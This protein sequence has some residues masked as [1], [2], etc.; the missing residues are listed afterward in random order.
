ML[1]EVILIGANEDLENIPKQFISVD[2]LL[3][4]FADLEKTT[5]EKSAQ[6]LL[7]HIHILNKT[8]KLVLK[9]KYTLIEYE[10][11]NNDFYNCPIEAIR[12]I[13]EGEEVFVTDSIGFA[14]LTILMS[15][16][17]IGLDI[18]DNIIKNSHAYISP[19]CYENDDNFY[20]NQCAY[21]ISIINNNPQ[22]KLPIK[23]E[24]NINYGYL[25][26][27]N[28]QAYMHKIALLMRLTH[29]LITLNRF[30]EEATKQKRIAFCLEEYGQY[31]GVANT[32]TNVSHFAN[33]INTRDSSKAIVADVMSKMLSQE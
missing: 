8:K 6:W 12:L 25:L 29:D 4:L 7:N 19:N 9:N 28:N 3:N 16:K 24:Q 26:N 23:Q 20:K 33:L 27:P 1:W 31:Y 21:L 10:Y 13:A 2:E 5:L 32:S 18:D 15:L 11:N 17:E 30:K 14:R 22:Q